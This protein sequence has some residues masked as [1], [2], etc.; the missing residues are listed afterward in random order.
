MTV[1]TKGL[2]EVHDPHLLDVSKLLFDAW[3]S[4]SAQKVA[5]CWMEADIIS[6]FIQSELILE[7]GKSL[8]SHEREVYRQEVEEISR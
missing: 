1:G 7:H 6:R 2:D 4:M 3:K 8:R 5:S